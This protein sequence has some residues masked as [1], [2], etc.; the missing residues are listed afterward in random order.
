LF[1]GAVALWMSVAERS[2]EADRSW[3]AAGLKRVAKKSC[4]S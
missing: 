1:A 2:G 4:T 3:R